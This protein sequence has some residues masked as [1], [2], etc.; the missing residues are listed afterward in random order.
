[1]AMRVALDTTPLL[2]QRTGIGTLVARLVEGLDER[3]DVELLRY[4]VSIRAPVPPGVRRFPYPARFALEAWSRGSTPSGR[5]TLRGADLVHGTNYVAPPTGWPTVVS[6][7]DVSFV[8]NPELATGAVRSFVPIIRRCIAGGAWVHTISEHVAGQVRELFDAERVRVVYPGATRTSIAASP[9]PPLPGIDGRRYVLAIG[10]REPRKNLARLV[11]AFGLLHETHTDTALVLAGPSGPDDATID[12]AIGRLSRP[13]AECVLVTDWLDDDQRDAVLAAAS[14]VA[15]PSLDEGFG[16]PALEGMA[17]GVP[18]VA[19]R[20]GAIPEVVGE[21]AVLVDP[22]EPADIADGLARALDDDALRADP[23]RRWPCAARPL[24]LVGDGRRDGLA[25]PGRPGGWRGGRPRDH[26]RR[27]RCRRRPLPARAR[28]GGRALERDGHRQHRRR[29]RAPRPHDLPRPGHRHLH[30]RRGHRPRTGLGAV[31][32]DVAGHGGPRPVRRGRARTA[33][34]PPPPGSTW[35]TPTSPRT[36]TGPTAGARGPRCRRSPPRSARP[37]G[38][39][40]AC[41]P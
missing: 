14:V 28:A 23:R 6:V 37:S 33:R 30:P 19:A 21:A 39:P 26:G 17:A 29:H 35:A 1:M 41:C 3:D 34:A 22:L 10:M 25:L 7:H 27:W 20:A 9:R 18:V 11:D 24:H 15:Y 38:C 8:T 2:G 12:A 4:A 32:G 31:R 16:F 5:R 36:S 13:A 40:S